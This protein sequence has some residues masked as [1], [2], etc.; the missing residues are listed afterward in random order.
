MAAHLGAVAVRDHAALGHGGD[1]VAQA[2]HQGH[3]VLDEQDGG[4]AGAAPAQ[5]QQQRA[6]RFRFRR[7]EPGRRFVQQQQDRLGQ[8]GAGNFKLAALPG[9]QLGH[10][11][12]LGSD[13]ANLLERGIGG[14]PERAVFPHGAG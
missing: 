9:R 3:V 12:V 14:D 5:T 4:L 7:G 13:E 2:E 1:R 11:R 6:Q 8:Q 10:R